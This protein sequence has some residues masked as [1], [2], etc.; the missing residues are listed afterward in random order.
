MTTPTT[1]VRLPGDP[2][3]PPP[4][5]RY[6]WRVAVTMFGLVALVLLV[7]WLGFQAVRGPQTSGQFPTAPTA[8]EYARAFQATVS[9]ADTTEPRA[10][11]PP[12]PQPTAAP[13]RAPTAVSAPAAAPGAT[14]QVATTVPS[15]IGA[16]TGIKVPTPSS[17][18]TPEAASQLEPVRT[19][20]SAT[21]GSGGAASPTPWPTVAPELEAAVSSAYTHYWQVTSDAFLSLDPTA[22]SQ[23]A[24]G[25]ELSRL[26]KHIEDERSA[27]HATQVKIQHSFFVLAA[28]DHQAQ[29]ADNYHD[30]SIWVDPDTHE[31]LPGQSEP[32]SIET[33][34][35]FKLIYDLQIVDGT[36]KVTDGVQVVGQGNTQ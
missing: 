5:P 28:N 35:E 23:V 17:A 21:A 6:P 31:P 12:T 9:A 30:F 13:T 7:V 26:Q 25:P 4:E 32:S 20:T 14:P 8:T 27:G 2:I 24:V 11:L 34:P 16:Q 29:V 22:L 36:W 10:T 1:P 3:P 33:A 18:Q 15:S 19:V